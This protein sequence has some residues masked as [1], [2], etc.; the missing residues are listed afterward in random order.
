MHKMSKW[1]WRA[2]TI[3]L[4]VLLLAYLPAL[5]FTDV[6]STNITLLPIWFWA[7]NVLLIALP[8]ITGLFESVR[9]KPGAG[10]LPV[11]KYSILVGLGFLLF[12]IGN[13]P[14]NGGLC[15][16]GITAAVLNLM[17]PVSNLIQRQ[18]NRNRATR[19]S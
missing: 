13:Y 1:L 18:R 7:I 11:S 12:A 5:L 4:L 19:T 16:L 9:P 3:T 17:Q 10:P 14:R 15:L 8:V 6:G 2:W